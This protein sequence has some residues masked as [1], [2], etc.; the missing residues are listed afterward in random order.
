MQIDATDSEKVK[1]LQSRLKALKGMLRNARSAHSDE[2][3]DTQKAQLQKSIQETEQ[4]ITSSKPV[5]EQLR[6]HNRTAQI[7]EQKKLELEQNLESLQ[8][9]TST[10]KQALRECEAKEEEAT[11][12]CPC[13]SHGSM[14]RLVQAVRTG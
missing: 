6:F 7:S 1:N 3:M 4:E 5:K 14:S 2:Y 10:V 9:A 11:P 13:I 12:R 8:A